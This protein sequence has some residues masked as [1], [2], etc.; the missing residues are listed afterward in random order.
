MFYH[1]ENK[2]FFTNDLFSFNTHKIQG[3][4]PWMTRI[5]ILTEKGTHRVAGQHF[6]R[7]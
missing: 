3:N 4:K 5:L 6:K 2:F 1:S 7:L